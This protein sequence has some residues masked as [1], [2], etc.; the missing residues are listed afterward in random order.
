MSDNKRQSVLMKLKKFLKGTCLLN[1][2]AKKY[3]ARELDMSQYGK[4]I[5]INLG[6][7]LKVCKDYINIDYSIPCLFSKTNKVIL[8]IV[9]F[10]LKVIGYSEL[11]RPYRFSINLNQFITIIQNNIFF[12]CDLLNGLPLKE[13]VVD[14]YYSSHMI[15]FSFPH[16]ISYNILKEMHRTMKPNGLIRLSLIDGD[17]YWADKGKKTLCENYNTNDN[18]FSFIE[19][20]E[21]LKKIG[22]MNIRKCKYQEGDYPDMI[23]LDDY[24]PKVDHALKSQTM[25]IE[26][27][28]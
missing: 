16:K 12:L 4:Q 25:Y 27:Y 17:F 10:Y 14:Y 19:I 20:E 1:Y 11:K 7:G 6:C 13:N 28:K 15:G 21:L 5:K 23:E 22:F 8:S 2:Y 9:Y 18:C 24:S 26:A 3:S